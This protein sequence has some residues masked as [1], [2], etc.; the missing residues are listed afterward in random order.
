MSEDQDKKKTKVTLIKHQHQKPEAQ[1]APREKKK[2]VVVKKKVV[3]KKTPRTVS[4]DTESENEPKRENPPK[5]NEARKS[6][7]STEGDSK[8]TSSNEKSSSGS[9][10]TYT[11]RSREARTGSSDRKRSDGNL[12][13]PRSAGRVGGAPRERS[14]GRVGGYN[15]ER[16]AGRVGGYNNNRQGGYN[17]NSGGGYN[18]NR[19][20]GGY[21]NN[22]PGG[23]YNNN[24]PGGG[25][26]NNRPGGGFNNNRPGG[27]YN[28][29]RPGGGYN[30]NRPGGFNSRPS[31]GN[32][33][34]SGGGNAPAPIPEN[35]GK[36]GSKKFFKSKKKDYHKKKDESSE[37]ILQYKKKTI[38]QTNP[39]PKEIDMMEVITVSELARKLNL[40]ASDLISK[41]MGMGMMVT[42]NQQIDAET[43][44][45]LADEYGCKVNLVSLYEET[46]IEMEE[47]RDEDLQARPPIVTVMGHVDHGK[48][49]LLD[50]I[51]TTNVVAGEFGGITQH[52][53]AYKVHTSRGELTFLD[54][55]GHAAFTLMRARGAQI[56]DIVILVVAAN[57]GVMPQ[58]R[59]AIN[60]AKEAGVPII[61]A[62]N[63]MDLPD[64]NP[65]KVK[66]Q[67]SE[68]GILSEDWGGSNQF[69]YISA[70]KREGIDELLD[71][72]LLEAEMLNLRANWDCRAEGKV[73]ES[74]VD[75]GRGT[76]STV[77]IERGVLK[78][79]DSFVA[80]IF[81]GKVRAMFDDHGQR[82]EEATPSTPVEI[83][84]ITGVP[85]SGDPFQVTVNDK[86][87][88]S[89]SQKR[90]ELKKVEEAKNV[91]KITLDNL[92]DSIQDGEVQELKVIIKG[93]VHGSVEALKATLEKLST[94]E[95]RLV[96]IHAAAG[97]IIENDV[98]LAAAS[99]AIIIGFHVRPTAKAQAVAEQEKVEIRKYN[100]IYD[101][102]QDIRDAMEGMLA[103]ELTEEVI[104]RV[105]VREVFKVPK[106]GLVAGCMVTS[107]I[108][109]RKSKIHLI[110]EGIEIHTGDINQLKRF[111]DDAKE[112]REGFECGISLEKFQDIQ[113][114]DELE[115]FE[116]KE[117]ARKLGEA[118]SN[119]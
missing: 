88:K 40:K 64:A 63:K 26:N 98:T 47:D 75:Q 66:Q 112:V 6:S 22:R 85:D 50:A 116:M 41:L 46:I 67:L 74:R 52:I 94:P 107:G 72:V 113:V 3:V 110:R 23:G 15:R 84:G 16:S 91:K 42:I 108:V 51:R 55:P 92:Y 87:A 18:N 115:V 70:L 2:V 96:C 5:E 36:T 44:T 14:A 114:G 54:T 32:F 99:N 97:A 7:S 30:N 77:L 61:V 104:G 56:T 111:K 93:D 119:E 102:E 57:D 69:C 31:G 62:V 9:S 24:R 10:P 73:I 48:T 71:T 33:G 100:I 28:N 60:H 68:Y 81:S 89:Y 53:G 4:H 79:G 39:V 78:V 43:A 38:N 35:Q 21:N 27:G 20:A 29:N 109:T 13:G 25:Y 80:G 83:I 103:P 118:T 58:T 17:G 106:I 11:S 101:A 49:K 76:V 45:I 105:E 95:I 19:P 65:E 90:Q 34:R 82:V 117:V 86:E 1:E 59:E 37:K 12:N 8:G